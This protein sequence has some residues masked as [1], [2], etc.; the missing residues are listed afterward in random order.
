LRNFELEKYFSKWEFSARHHMTASDIESMTIEELLSYAKQEQKEEFQKT[1]LGYTETWGAPDLR[2]TIANTYEN[3]IQKENILCFAGAG[4]GIYIASRVLL[5]KNDHAIVV[6]PNYQSAETIPLEI[7]SVSGVLLHYENNWKLDIDDIKKAIRP[8]TKLISI[9]FPHNPTG[10]TMKDEDLKELIELCRK[11]NIYL[12]S[13]EVYRGVEVDKSNQMP[14]VGDIY[15]KGLSLNVLS[16]A[17][18]LPGLRVGWIASQDKEILLKMERYKHYLSICN[19]A[20]SERLSIIAIENREKI[21]EKNRNMLRENL[22]T[23]EE[24][25]KSYPMLFDWKTP[26]GGC[27]AYPKYIGEDGVEEFCKSLIE[28][29]GILLLPSSLYE[30]ELMNAPK[31]HFRIGYGRKESFN[32]GLKA[33]Q[34]HIEKKYKDIIK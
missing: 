11:H 10:S 9:N 23:I 1:W 19:S 7:C 25:F 17:Y 12:F 8:N 34:E 32:S 16:K 14:Q 5:N 3:N 29:S 21:F 26:K 18:G 27:I 30:S 13:D 24:F 28:E 20:P 2:E 33:M 6:V 22:K 4:E 15:E 31:N